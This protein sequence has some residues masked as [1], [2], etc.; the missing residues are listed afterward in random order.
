[1]RCFDYLYVKYN[2]SVNVKYKWY[3]DLIYARN[4]AYGFSTQHGADS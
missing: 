3:A 4:G 1:M 2:V